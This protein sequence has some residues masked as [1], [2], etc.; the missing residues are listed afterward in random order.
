MF[1]NL[2][3]RDEFSEGDHTGRLFRMTR[4]IKTADENHSLP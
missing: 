4:T 2:K 3:S 1:I